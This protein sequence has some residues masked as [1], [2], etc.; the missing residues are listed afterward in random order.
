MS[1]NTK[2]L[3]ITE[4]DFD[5]IKSNLKTFLQNQSEFNSYNF[6]GSGLAVLLD[7]LAY[8]THYNAF[9][10]NMVSNE[11][12]LD[13]AQLRESVISWAKALNYSPKSCVGATTNINIKITPGSGEDNVSQNLVLNKYTPFMSEP[14]DG[15][16]YNFVTLNSVST[17]KTANGTFEFN[18]VPIIQGDLQ[19]FYYTVDPTNTKRRFTIPSPTIDTSTIVV[20][21][22]ESVSNVATTSYKM[23]DDYVSLTA[24]STVYFVEENS[25]ANGS[26]TLYF[27]DNVIGQSPANGNIILLNYLDTQ[28]I[29][30]NKANSFTSTFPIG[31]YSANIIV[32]SVSPSSGGAQK[33]S[34]ND[35]RKRAP[36]AYGT[37]NRAVTKTDY[38]SIILSN[39]N[40]IQ[41]A[42]VWGGEENDPPIYGKVFVSLKPFDGYYITSDL[43]NTIIQDI[44][45]NKGMLTVIPEIV[46]PDYTYILFISKVYFDSRKTTLNSDQLSSLVN[47]SIQDYIIAEFNSFDSTLRDS[48]II[49]NILDLDSGITSNSLKVILQ[50]RIQPVLNQGQN[51]TIDFGAPIAKATTADKFYTYPEVSILD[52]NS[53]PQ[54]VL[55]EEVPGSDTGIDSISIINPGLNYTTPPTIQILG[56]GTGATAE[57]VIVNGKLN[58]INVLTPGT[59]YTIATINI[60]GGGSGFGGVASINLDINSGLIRTYYLKPTGEKVIVNSHAGTISYDKGKIVLSN[61][62]PLSVANSRYPLGTLTF[63]AY[64]QDEIISSS[65][66]KIIT[67]DLNDSAG[68]AI[69]MIAEG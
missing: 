29:A 3:R 26:F 1:T 15:L 36:I 51:Y 55:F 34:I 28:G 49:S 50:K 66:D 25:D 62:Y 5:S 19:N 9:M 48:S 33:E 69:T 46:D 38:Q 65:R 58:S 7:L 18:N 21:V 40:Y 20:S 24:N 14:L 43:K 56:D 42:S 32:S 22:Q 17:T 6:E 13:T 12:F 35:V 45:S 53:L 59:N 47:A 41:S 27:G 44:I 64:S 37:Q 31:G 11:M 39:Y 67:T 8:N 63:N 68:I 16:A 2:V 30:A 52:I 60:I 10:H 23:V 61:L 4:M 54:S 57:A